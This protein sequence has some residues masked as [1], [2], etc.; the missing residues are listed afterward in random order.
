MITLEFIHPKQIVD[1]VTSQL[2]TLIC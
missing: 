2:E 1:E